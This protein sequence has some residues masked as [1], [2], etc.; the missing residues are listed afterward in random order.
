[1]CVASFES[2]LTRSLNA[3]SSAEVHQPESDEEVLITL[4]MWALKYVRFGDD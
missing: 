1:M 4:L 3:L 2:F